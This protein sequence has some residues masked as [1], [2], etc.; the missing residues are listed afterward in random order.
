MEMRARAIW[1]EVF[2]LQPWSILSLRLKRRFQNFNVYIRIYAY[3]YVKLNIAIISCKFQNEFFRV[4]FT[5][6]GPEIEQTKLFTN[7]SLYWI[8]RERYSTRGGCAQRSKKERKKLRKLVTRSEGTI[9]GIVRWPPS[10]GVKKEREGEK[11]VFRQI[12]V[13]DG[14]S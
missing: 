3:T 9:R 13:V 12:S 14:R 1:Q 7:L 4:P 5:R 6:S 10:K 8:L 2:L 11:F